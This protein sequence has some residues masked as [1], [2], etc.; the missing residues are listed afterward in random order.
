VKGDDDV[1]VADVV[2]IDVI[3]IDTF[4]LLE[5]EEST[6]ETITDG[7]VEYVPTNV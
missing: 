3:V 6:V 5:A 4:V 2:L 1:I 7:A